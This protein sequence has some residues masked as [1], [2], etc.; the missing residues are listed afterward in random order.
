MATKST[1]GTKFTTA[2][3]IDR[4]PMGARKTPFADRTFAPFVLFVANP[5]FRHLR[6][7]A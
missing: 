1:N 5:P 2:F 4:A 7:S 6:P 3:D